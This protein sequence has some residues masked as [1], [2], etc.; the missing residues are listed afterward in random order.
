MMYNV[1]GCIMLLFS[2]AALGMDNL[3]QSLMLFE[4]T[5]A[6]PNQATL[7]QRINGLDLPPDFDEKTSLA[8]NV[9]KAEKIGDVVCVVITALDIYNDRIRAA[10]NITP[11][12]KQQYIQILAT[13]KSPLVRALLQDQPTVLTKL[14]EKKIIE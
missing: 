7:K 10:Q 11:E 4:Q 12:N 5:I 1:M 14:K 3:E 13:Q 9:S 2:S 8:F 6:L